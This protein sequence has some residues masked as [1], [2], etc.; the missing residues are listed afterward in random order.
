MQVS[1]DKYR[2]TLKRDADFWQDELDIVDELSAPVPLSDAQLII[3][4]SDESADVIWDVANGKLSMPATGVIR[5]TVSLE[6][7]TS[8]TWTAG[9]YCLSVT[10]TNGKRD[11]SFLTG[12]IRIIDAC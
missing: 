6:E 12:P 10:Y 2:I 4:P 5:F 8:Y 3:H 7:I 1:T 11:R 9:S